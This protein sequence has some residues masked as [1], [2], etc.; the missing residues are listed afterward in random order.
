MSDKPIGSG[1]SERDYDKRKRAHESVEQNL[2]KNGVRPEKARELAD[3]AA[4]EGD[5]N[6]ANKKGK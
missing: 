3:K 6:M 4:R 2:I 1:I 5:A